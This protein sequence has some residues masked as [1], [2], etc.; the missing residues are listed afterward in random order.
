MTKMALFAKTAR[1][2]RTAL[3][4]FVMVAAFSGAMRAQSI[5]GIWQGTLPVDR[6]AR[7]VVRIS[8][9]TEGGLRGVYNLVDVDAD[10]YLLSSVVFHAPE[11]QLT[12]DLYAVSFRGKLAADGA[13]L[14]G[15]WT[16]ANKSYPL[17]LTRTA[18]AAVW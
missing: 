7:I 10:G 12:S 3:C 17:V 13:S 15:T 2:V 16:Q 5:T 18:P 1:A 9:L 4:V 11:V 6:N 14:S 8:A